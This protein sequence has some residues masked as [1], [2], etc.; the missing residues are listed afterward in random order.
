MLLRVLRTLILP[1]A[2]PPIS[3]VIVALCMHPNL[4]HM[5]FPP[6]IIIDRLKLFLPKPLTQPLILP[7]LVDKHVLLPY[8]PHKSSLSLEANLLD[9]MGNVSLEGERVFN[10]ILQSRIPFLENVPH[11][12]PL[13]SIV[14]SV[15]S[16]GSSLPPCNSH[17]KQVKCLVAIDGGFDPLD[18]SKYQSSWSLALFVSFIPSGVSSMEGFILTLSLDVSSCSQFKVASFP[19]T[20]SAHFSLGRQL[21]WAHTALK[22]TRNAWNMYSYALT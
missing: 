17:S 10:S 15:L 2:L 9:T 3:Q 7:V 11:G 16:W 5:L 4:F 18:K 19:W 6:L 12:C 21:L 20:L 14:Q 22:F 1:F 13:P 8:V